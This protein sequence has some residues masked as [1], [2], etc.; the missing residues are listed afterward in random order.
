MHTYELLLRLYNR[1]RYISYYMWGMYIMLLR[2]SLRI[3]HQ[4]INSAIKRFFSK[5]NSYYALITKFCGCRLLSIKF[6]PI[7]LDRS[8]STLIRCALILFFISHICVLKLITYKKNSFL[9][10]RTSI[11]NGCVYASQFISKMYL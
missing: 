10:I 5:L 3:L 4:F 7:R 9:V 1:W 8:N 6:N 2:W 11:Y